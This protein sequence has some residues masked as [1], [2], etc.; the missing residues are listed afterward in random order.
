LVAPPIIEW[1][2]AAPHNLVSEGVVDE[3]I[4]ETIKN[5]DR[6]SCVVKGGVH[7]LSDSTAE[8]AG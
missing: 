2:L 8:Y 6:A 3:I 5:H 1:W 4:F 7:R